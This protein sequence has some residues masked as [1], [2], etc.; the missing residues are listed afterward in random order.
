MCVVE[1]GEEGFSLLHHC[2]L[3]TSFKS[4]HLFNRAHQKP[5]MSLTNSLHTDTTLQTFPSPRSSRIMQDT[6]AH[7][8]RRHTM[9]V[10]DGKHRTI[11]QSETTTGA[12]MVSRHRVFAIRVG[13]VSWNRDA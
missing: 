1:Q 10:E 13:G 7:L 4:V 5:C 2:S 3:L 12:S 8:N 9:S 6:R 11:I